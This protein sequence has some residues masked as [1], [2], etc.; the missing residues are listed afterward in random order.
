M[1]I[2]DKKFLKNIS[3]LYVEDNH[4]IA[5]E[6]VFFL[7]PMVKK[8]LCAYNGKEGLELFKKYKPDIIITDIQMPILNGIDMINEIRK[9]DTNIPIIITTAFNEPNYLLQAIDMDVDKYLMKPIQIKK[10]KNV[11]LDITEQKYEKEQLSI[12][13]YELEQLNLNLKKRVD[14][15][16]EK[17]KLQDTILFSQS[18]TAQMGEMLR[19]I[20]HQWRQPLNAISASV[21]KLDIQNSLDTL[22]EDSISQTSNFI[23]KQTQYMSNTINNFMDFFKPNHD[24]EEFTIKELYEEMDSIIN[25]QI[26]SKEITIELDGS[27]IKIYSYKK[28]LSHVLLNLVANSRDAFEDKN[29]E[30]KKIELSVIQND[31]SVKIIFKDNAGGIDEDKIDKIFNAYFTTKEQGKGTG[32]GLYMSKRIINE[33]LNGEIYVKNENNGVVFTIELLS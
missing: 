17:N 3:V 6:I 9:V 30:N 2:K 19:M 13:K 25:A 4:E 21:I 33:V 10:L 7:E 16:V 8:L 18:K 12:Y 11:L 23:Q 31:K 20:A 32:I 22:N 26:K 27:D 28:E 15:E 14:E 29:I 5:E 24:K 1:L